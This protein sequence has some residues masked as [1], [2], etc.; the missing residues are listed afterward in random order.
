MRAKQIDEHTVEQSLRFE[1]KHFD[2]T[3]TMMAGDDVQALTFLLHIGLVELELW[4]RDGFSIWWGEKGDLDYFDFWSYKKKPS[5][6]ALK[7]AFHFP[8]MAAFEAAN[9]GKFLTP[10]HRVA[11]DTDRPCIQAYEVQEDGSDVIGTMIGP[12]EIASMTPDE[13]CHRLGR[14]LLYRTKAGRKILGYDF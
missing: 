8:A 11:V 13:I 3:Q 6:F 2:M 4:T 14:M 12:D 5:E 1:C 10:S 7:S 9:E